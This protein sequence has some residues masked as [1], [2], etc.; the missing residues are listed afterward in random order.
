MIAQPAAT[1]SPSSSGVQVEQE[2][3]VLRASLDDAL[4]R[5]S[6]LEL[7]SKPRSPLF[8]SNSPAMAFAKELCAEIFPGP[9]K[10]EVACAPDEPG[11][12]WYVLF[13]DCQAAMD[14]CLKRE[15]EFGLRLHDAFPLEGGDIRLAVSTP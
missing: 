3:L 14:D 2:L 15:I 7:A 1:P 4:R 13:V 9:L 12:Q 11:D 8:P 10:V 6:N 5:I